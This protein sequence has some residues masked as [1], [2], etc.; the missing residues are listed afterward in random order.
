MK[1]RYHSEKDLYLKSFKIVREVW[2]LRRMPSTE[3]MMTNRTT[4]R[5]L[6]ALEDSRN[7]IMEFDY[8]TLWSVYSRTEPLYKSGKG[9]I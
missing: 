3:S 2:Y 4:N 5:I 1:N 9:I 7:H 8:E 6:T